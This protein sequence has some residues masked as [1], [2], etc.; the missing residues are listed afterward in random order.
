MAQT[1][2]H[3]GPMHLQAHLGECNEDLEATI[4]SSVSH[5]V[6]TI[7]AICCTCAP[8]NLSRILDEGQCSGDPQQRRSASDRVEQLDRHRQK[9]IS[10]GSSTRL[11]KA[12]SGRTKSNST[13]RQICS[14]F[15]VEI[16]EEEGVV[17][18]FCRRCQ[19]MFVVFDRCLYWGLRRDHASPPESFPY[20]CLCGGHSFE[21]GV[22]FDYS[23]DALDENDF[24]TVTVAVRCCACTVISMILDEE[25]G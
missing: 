4:R 11:Q 24:H 21:L 17:R 19:K 6:S 15:A 10:R 22:G 18:G 7:R 8:G 2:L 5:S 16:N 20:R 3:S 14:L 1:P 23:D 9:R 13:R 25:G 12:V